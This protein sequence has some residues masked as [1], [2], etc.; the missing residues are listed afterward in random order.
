M[1]STSTRFFAAHDL[2]TGAK[3]WETRLATGG[4]GTTVTYA[5]GGRQYIGVVTSSNGL[6]NPGDAIH[7]DVD[8]A[9][10]TGGNMI[11]VFALP[12]AR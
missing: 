5:V 4:S 10:G 1:M 12:A 9:T 11:Y 8:S 7:A 2:D 6:G 3:I